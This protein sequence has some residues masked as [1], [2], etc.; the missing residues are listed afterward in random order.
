MLQNRCRITYFMVDL[1]VFC[2]EKT[3]N[4]PKLTVILQ[5]YFKKLTSSVKTNCRKPVFSRLFLTVLHRTLF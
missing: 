4:L 5:Y 2:G 3:E 1:P